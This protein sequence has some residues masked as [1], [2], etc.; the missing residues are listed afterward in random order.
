MLGRGGRDGK[1]AAFV[2]LLWVGQAGTSTNHFQYLICKLVPLTRRTWLKQG[3]GKSAPRA[4]YQQAELSE[5]GLE[6]H[7]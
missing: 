5:D 7:V 2:V 4:K 1:N 6:F 3:F